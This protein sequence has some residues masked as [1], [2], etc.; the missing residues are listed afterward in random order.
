[1]ISIQDVCQENTV[2]LAVVGV[3]ASGS[4]AAW[5]LNKKYQGNWKIKMFDAN[6]RVGGRL[7]SIPITG[8]E[9]HVADVGAMRF[10]TSHN[11]FVRVI[12]QLGLTVD[13]FTTP[14]KQDTLYYLRDKILTRNDIETGNVPYQMT[15][16]ERSISA[17]TDALL[18]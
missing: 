15:D 2:D 14:N 13:N 10:K 17:D 1:M 3:G 4:F 16:Y 8:I 9:N 18:A 12:N 11:S 6:N 5:Q 7:Y